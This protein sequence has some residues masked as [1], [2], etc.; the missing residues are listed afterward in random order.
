MPR[1]TAACAAIACCLTASGAAAATEAR[2][3]RVDARST[4]GDQ[5]PL[6]TTLIDVGDL[7]PGGFEARELPADATLLLEG[8]ARP[9]ELVDRTLWSTHT[10]PGFGTAWLVV[11]DS[12]RRMGTGLARAKE[13][14]LELASGL[15]PGDA[16]DVVVVDDRQIVADTGWRDTTAR[17]AVADSIRGVSLGGAQRNR[18]FLTLLESAS[19]TAFGA[20]PGAKLSRGMPLHQAWVVLSTGYGGA[21]PKSTGPGGAELARVFEQGRLPRENTSAPKAPIPIVSVAFPTDVLPEHRHNAAEL[22]R[23]LA[24]PGVGGA[25]HA[26]DAW[27]EH[28]ARTIVSQVRKRFDAMHVVRW[29][30]PCVAPTATQSLRLEFP[31]ARGPIVGD[32]TFRDVPLGAP[33]RFPLAVDFERTAREVDRAGG[34]APGDTLRVYGRFCWGSD[35]AR[36]HAHFLPRGTL[37]P[38]TLDDA[39]SAR[40]EQS[41]SDL[42]RT[43]LSSTA[44]RTDP[45][46]VEVVVP[47]DSRLAGSDLRVVLED[48]A[49][50]RTSGL[51]ARRVVTLR[52]RRAWPRWL[53]WS[54]GAL[55]ATALVG[56]WWALRRR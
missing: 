22:M 42:V 36:A 2:L 56:G 43:G 52:A 38:Q 8:A 15:R 39:D 24:N 45:G 20:L 13:V 7:G 10:E 40:V 5:T 49:G 27:S 9:A 33:L 14:A 28:S 19:K 3:I 1:R 41:R 29:R 17:A 4:D 55:A 48:G 30:L 37:L 51:T 23:A 6:L 44:T 31:R 54:L 21:D 32:A 26:V 50:P 16:I 35:R 53:P 25:Y 34:V 46:F 18:G 47:R 12:D 11:L